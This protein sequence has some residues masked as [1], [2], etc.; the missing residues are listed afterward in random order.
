MRVLFVCRGNV[1]R[2]QMAAALF[3]KYFGEDAFSAGTKVFEKQG[4]KLK[5]IPLAEPVIRFMKK[6]DIDISENAR[7]Q[8]THAMLKGFDKII[9]MAE[10]ETI[11]KYLHQNKAEFWD[12]EDPKDMSDKGYEKIISQ[13]KSRIKHLI[14]DIPWWDLPSNII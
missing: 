12:I 3:H 14:K 11:P 4:Q 5:E 6:E 7:T 13:I 2:S 10:Q 1:G 8:L 9:V